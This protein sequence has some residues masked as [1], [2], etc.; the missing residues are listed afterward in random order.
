[1]GAIAANLGH[2][3]PSPTTTAG[4][5]LQPGQRDPQHPNVGMWRWRD[6]AGCASPCYAVTTHPPGDKRGLVVRL[7]LHGR[8][9]HHRPS[10]SPL[11]GCWLMGTRLDKGHPISNLLPRPEQ[12]YLQGD[13]ECAPGDGGAGLRQGAAIGRGVA[14][15]SSCA[16]SRVAVRCRG[17]SLPPPSPPQLE[18][19]MLQ[20]SCNQ[21]H[22]LWSEASS[23][24]MGKQMHRETPPNHQQN[25][26]EGSSLGTVSLP[27]L[28]G[29]TGR[30]PGS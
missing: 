30:M 9:A 29:L 6:G 26:G 2:L 7:V 18:A 4:A 28:P 15:V 13:K 27:S 5:N 23:S 10:Q 14:S 16:P 24:C 19:S 11:E 21:C 1:M 20:S 8:Q 17:G 3:G 12:R 22:R 25:W